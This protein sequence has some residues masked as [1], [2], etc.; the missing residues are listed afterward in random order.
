MEK[1]ATTATSQVSIEE[2]DMSNVMWLII[3]LD[4][5]KIPIF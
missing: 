1:S 5:F 2:R 3:H 4:C